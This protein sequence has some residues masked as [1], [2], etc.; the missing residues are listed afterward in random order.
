MWKG[1]D[2]VHTA[3]HAHVLLEGVLRL[4]KQLCSICQ[5]S[6]LP[7]KTCVTCQCNP[8]EA[9]CKLVTVTFVAGADS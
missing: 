3:L 9:H 1:S 2:E 4:T 8:L 7:N 5:R 6:L